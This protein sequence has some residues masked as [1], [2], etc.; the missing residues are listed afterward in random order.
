MKKLLTVLCTASGLALCLPAFAGDADDCHFH[1]SKAAS[2]ETVS[3][4]AI[5]R[6]QALITS[7]KIDK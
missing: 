1:G 7:G 4:C 6:Q 3:G 5:K 2:Q